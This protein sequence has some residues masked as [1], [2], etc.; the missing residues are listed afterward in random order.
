MTAKDIDAGQIRIPR[1]P[2]KTIL[3]RD[4]QNVSVLLRG[5]ELTCRW[6]PRYGPPERSGVIR[7]GKAPAQELLK[8]GDVLGVH[9]R[10]PRIA[11]AE[12][13]N[14]RRARAESAAPC[15]TTGG[16]RYAQEALV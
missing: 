5:H 7:L 11:L 6:D 9:A 2:T 15:A 12:D 16:E 8:P 10:P 13:E 1:G 4:R 3:P 14:V